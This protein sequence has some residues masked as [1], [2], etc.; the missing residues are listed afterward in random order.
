MSLLSIFIAEEENKRAMI[1]LLTL[2]ETLNLENYS[3]VVD[4]VNI[5]MV[6]EKVKSNVN[7]LTAV[8]YSNVTPK[9]MVFKSHQC[10]KEFIKKALDLQKRIQMNSNWSL[11]LYNCLFKN[12]F[13]FF[14]CS[15]WLY[16][17]FSC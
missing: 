3:S 12:P 2:F 10:V 9:D 15:V 17:F 11:W 13:L 6:N 1:D 16:F 5:N 8:I 14:C 7:V 4:Y